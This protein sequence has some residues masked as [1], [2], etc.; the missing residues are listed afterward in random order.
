MYLHFEY[1][2]ILNEL[3][4]IDSLCQLSKT[5][6]EENSFDKI[7]SSK[8]ELELIELSANYFNFADKNRLFY[9]DTLL[10]I[11]SIINHVNCWATP[12][13]SD[14]LTEI[15][16]NSLR[17]QKEYAYLVLKSLIE[18]NPEQ[19]KICMPNLIPVIASDIHN[20]SKDVKN[21]AS[22]VLELLLECSGNSDLD[23]FIPDV[24]KGIKDLKSFITQ[25]KHWQVVYLFKL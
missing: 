19:I 12:F 17:A 13:I 22:Y 21:N 1:Y 20:I 3:S 15:I 11:N 2:G 5:I 4:N 6:V 23:I 18:K 25:S 10:V 14:I 7:I 9:N 8:S 16:N 24:L